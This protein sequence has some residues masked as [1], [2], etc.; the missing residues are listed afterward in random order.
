[1]PGESTFADTKT[2]EV[3]SINPVTGEPQRVVPA[4]TAKKPY[5]SPEITEASIT[6]ESDIMTSDGS[7]SLGLWNRFKKAIGFG[8]K[9]IDDVLST[10]QQ[11][12]AIVKELEPGVYEVTQNGVVKYG[13]ITN[14]PSTEE[15]FDIQTVSIYKDGNP[16]P[17]EVTKYYKNSPVAQRTV[18]DGENLTHIIYDRGSKYGVSYSG[19]DAKGNKVPGQEQSVSIIYGDEQKVM[20]T[21]TGEEL[22]TALLAPTRNTTDMYASYLLQV[23][24]ALSNFSP[25][26]RIVEWQA[27]DGTKHLVSR[28]RQYKPENFVRT[29]KAEEV[30]PYTDF[31]TDT[32]AFSQK[33]AEYNEF[34]KTRNLTIEQDGKKLVFKNEKGN[35][36][37]E[38]ETTKDG[39]GVKRDTFYELTRDGEVSQ[40]VTRDGNGKITTR[41]LNEYRPWWGKACTVT[42]DY[43]NGSAHTGLYLNG[44]LTQPKTLTLEQGLSRFQEIAG[45]IN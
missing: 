8:D 27:L 28:G 45:F 40:S 20:A 9:T 6:G 25:S 5:D 31:A 17:V 12:G 19:Y 35:V 7:P 37:R 14:V 43:V 41:T 13:K 32:P 23:D 39:T 24:G 33:I 2:G 38:I 1:M 22:E 16:E 44:E 18:R 29:V 34:A 21:Y 15:N 10:A 26:S 11:N 3:S 4:A 36:V 42:I 30:K